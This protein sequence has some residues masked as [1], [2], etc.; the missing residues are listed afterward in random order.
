MPRPTPGAPPWFRVLEAARKLSPRDSHHFTAVD[1]AREAGLEDTAKSRGSQIA[2]AWLS[3]LVKWGYVNFVEKIDAG[4]IRPTNSYVVT[5]AGRTC[6][7]TE[8]CTA[9]LARLVAGVR[10]LQKVYRTPKA[11]AAFDALVKLADEMDG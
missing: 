10:A 8:G 7:V 11:E 1:L 9:R 5:P 2:A 4:G 3:K 6:E